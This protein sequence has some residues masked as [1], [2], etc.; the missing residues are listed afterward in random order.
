VG[1]VT[2]K[3]IVM[4]SDRLVFHHRPIE[5]VELVGHS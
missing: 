5:V 3:F 1:G 4:P 2:N